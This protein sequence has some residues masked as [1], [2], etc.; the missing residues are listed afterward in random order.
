MTF[1]V[2][3]HVCSCLEN[4][5]AC[6]VWLVLRSRVVRVVGP[7]GACSGWTAGG[8]RM[9]RCRRPRGGGW[10]SCL[11][12][13]G[14]PWR[15]PAGDPTPPLGTG[16]C[17]HLWLPEMQVDGLIHHQVSNPHMC[18]AALHVHV[19]VTPF[20]TLQYMIT[21]LGRSHFQVLSGCLIRRPSSHFMFKEPDTADGC[22]QLEMRCIECN[23]A[24]NAADHRFLTQ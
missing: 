11:R 17:P 16:A 8:R 10:G 24:C 15:S 6:K 18:A 9:R 20:K 3:F 19:G 4:G 23:E 5:M 21:S 1:A 2:S 7:A 14:P 13:W 22:V 12:C